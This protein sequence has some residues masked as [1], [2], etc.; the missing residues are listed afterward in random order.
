MQ[1]QSVIRHC[2]CCLN[3][4]LTS[5]TMMLF[6]TFARLHIHLWG[7]SSLQL[8]KTAS[9]VGLQHTYTLEHWGSLTCSLVQSFSQA[10]SQSARLQWSRGFSV[11]REVPRHL[12]AM[13]WRDGLTPV[14]IKDGPKI[15]GPDREENLMWIDLGKSCFHLQARQGT[16]LG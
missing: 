1:R 10:S 15:K 16:Y 7:W 2:F 6:E 13:A 3:C 4:S 12:L 8:V 5:S 9:L 14:C 11:I